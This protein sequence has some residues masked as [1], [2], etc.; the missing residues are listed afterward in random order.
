MFPLAKGGTHPP[1]PV[2]Q[3]HLSPASDGLHFDLHQAGLGRF[4]YI[5]LYNR[6]FLPSCTWDC[7]KCP[8]GSHPTLTVVHLHIEVCSAFSWVGQSGVPFKLN[9]SWADPEVWAD[10]TSH[11]LFTVHCHQFFLFCPHSC[12][13][14]WSFFWLDIKISTFKHSQ[15]FL[16][17]ISFNSQIFRGRKKC[18]QH[19]NEQEKTRQEEG[20]FYN[21][22][23]V[24]IL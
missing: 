11:T 5:C 18:E 12:Q 20:W 7:L 16:K 19:R 23:R 2:A 22:A 1:L 17:K 3:T 6:A 10:K 9:T 4:F 15:T 13:E 24:D 8:K 14:R 21:M